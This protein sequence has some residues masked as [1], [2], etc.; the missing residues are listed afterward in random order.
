MYR[1]A[2]NKEKLISHDSRH[3]SP[4]LHDSRFAL[5]DAGYI[6]ISVVVFGSVFLT[7]LGGLVGFVFLQTRAQGIKETREKAL[8]IAEAGLDYYKWHLAH[9]PND[10]MNGATTSGPIIVPYRDPEGDVIGEFELGLASEQYCGQTNTVSITATGTASVDPSIERVVYARYAR[11]S[12]ASYAYILNSNVWA[13]SDRQI[14]GNYHSNGGIR[15][16]GTNDSLVTSAVST[17]LC[18][19]SFGCSP[20]STTPGVWGGG[21][22]FTLWQ[23]PLPQIDF[24]GITTDL[25]QIKTLAVAQGVYINETSNSDQRG[26]R[27]RFNADGTVTR[28]RVTGT[29]AHSS[30]HVDTGSTWHSD[31]DVITATQNQTTFT[32]PADCPVIFVEAKTWIDGVITQKVIV[33]ADEIVSPS[34]R[35]DVILNGNITYAD[36]TGLDGLTVIADR[37]VLIPFNSPNDMTL[38][39]IFIAQSGY[40][41]RNYYPSSEGTGYLRNSLTVSGTIVSNGREGTKWSSGGTVVSGYQLRTNA[42]DQDLSVSPPPLTPTIS[43]EFTFLEWQEVE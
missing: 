2:C 17:W 28:W 29:S 37:S 12:V 41:G 16:D 32:I 19:S 38:N 9:F 20:S 22:N 3:A 24:A 39:G 7:I 10:L 1:V 26:I 18:T 23:Q 35:A 30:Q 6:V 34:S 15:M 14:S 42:Y 11:P 5:H 8:Q 21:P 4:A 25:A 43:D 13:G 40:F 36:N 31:Y 33:A 27:L